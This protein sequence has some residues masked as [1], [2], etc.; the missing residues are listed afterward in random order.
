MLKKG[1]EDDAKQ[2]NIKK[3]IIFFLFFC[4]LDLMILFSEAKRRK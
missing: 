2:V 4:K 1:G 3:R